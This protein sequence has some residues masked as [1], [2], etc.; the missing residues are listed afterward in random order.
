[1]AGLGLAAHHFLWDGRRPGQVPPRVPTTRSPAST[2][3]SPQDPC[4][5]LYRMICQQSGTT[6]DPSGTVRTD[7]DGEQAAL[8][9][10]RGILEEHPGL[11]PEQAEEQLVDAIYTP[12]RTQ[13]VRSAFD[14]A[15]DQLEKFIDRQPEP[16]FSA[17]EKRLLKGQLHHV[18]LQLPPPASNYEDEP[19]LFTKNGAYYERVDEGRMRIRIGGA[20]LLSTD[21]WFNLVFT[22]AHEL[23]HSIDP[24]EL[25]ALHLSLPAYDRLG[26]CLMQQRVVELGRERHECADNDQLSEAFADWMAVQVVAKGLKHFS[27]EFDR[28]QLR[29]AV[30]NSVRD[31]CDQDE[32]LEELDLTQ[33]PSPEVRIEAIFGSHPVIREILG[34]PKLIPLPGP[35]LGLDRACDFSKGMNP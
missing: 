33:H 22:L 25:R 18:E 35:L 7:R 5:Q 9:A 23:A 10:Y 29:H 16:V 21:S 6:R 14:W 27:T 13:R 15:K 30:R 3:E 20:Y 24:C 1:M 2:V 26:A 31:L 8:D 4:H 28:T 34:C 12:R 17:R 19:D 32:S 11:E